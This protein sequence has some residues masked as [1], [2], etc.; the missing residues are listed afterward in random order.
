VAREP[1]LSAW[2]RNT[3]ASRD[4]HATSLRLIGRE[5]PYFLD[6]FHL[7]NAYM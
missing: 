7:T 5:S 1:V 2:R 6:F 4:V 3:V